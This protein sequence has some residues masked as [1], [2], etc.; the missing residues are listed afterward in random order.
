MTHNNRIKK[1]IQKNKFKH[2]LRPGGYKATIPLYAKK[3]QELCEAGIPD[4]LEGCTLHTRNMI[5]GQSRIDDNGQ[6]VTSNFD[7]TRV[8]ENTKNH[9]TKEKTSEFK[10]QH[11]KDQLSAALKT[12]EH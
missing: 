7:I 10:P 1:L 5:R 11:Q 12:E 2:R 6:L 9:I 3:E 8:I 4:P